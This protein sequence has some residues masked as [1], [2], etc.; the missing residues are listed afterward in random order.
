MRFAPS[1][2]AESV[3]RTK[4]E[5]RREGEKEEEEKKTKQKSSGGCGGR[6]GS[7]SLK[8]STKEKNFRVPSFSH[9]F[10]P[11]PLF[12]SSFSISPFFLLLLRRLLFFF[13]VTEWVEAS[14]SCRCCTVCA[15]GPSVAAAAS[16]ASVP[17]SA[18]ASM[19][20]CVLAAAAA[21]A[22]TV[23]ICGATAG[24]ELSVD[25]LVASAMARAAVS[26]HPPPWPEGVRSEYQLED[27][28]PKDSRLHGPDQSPFP[29]P[30]TRARGAQ[31]ARRRPR[32]PLPRAAPA[33]RP[34]AAHAAAM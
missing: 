31:A 27:T 33:R 2:R 11:F 10:F 19:A 29:A 17:A 1:L 8:K 3:K 21:A 9:L 32:H 24:V 20:C 30:R 16:V 13:S 4:K 14:V 12:V 7:E 15:R 26:L 28:R 34:C 18:S 22:A 5:R 25:V 6:A 23:L